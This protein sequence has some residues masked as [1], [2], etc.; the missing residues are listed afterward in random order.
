[1]LTVAN[2]GELN[3]AFLLL[4][5]LTETAASPDYPCLHE[6]KLLKHVILS[7]QVSKLPL[8]FNFRIN[9]QCMLNLF[10]LLPVVLS[11]R[12]SQDLLLQFIL[13]FLS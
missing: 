13:H 8:I 7:G 2:R 5:H 10:S 12:T 11:V 1:M 9:D 4:G 3:T 6:T